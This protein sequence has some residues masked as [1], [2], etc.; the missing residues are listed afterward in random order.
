MFC[1]FRNHLNLPLCATWGKMHTWY[2]FT[3]VIYVKGVQRFALAPLFAVYVAVYRICHIYHIFR[4]ESCY[5]Y[6]RNASTH[7][8]DLIKQPRCSS[9]RWYR[10]HGNHD[11][12][13]SYSPNRLQVLISTL[14]FFIQIFDIR[15][16]LI[17]S[18][19]EIFPVFIRLAT[20]FRHSTEVGGNTAPDSALF[21]R[22][23]TSY[24]WCIFLYK[25]SA[26]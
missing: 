4:K 20:T 10:H 1:T 7:H 16:K 26:I 5:D 8:N 22:P 6:C 3:Y 23:Y 24:D 21:H 12:R 2:R 11:R 17:Y 13:G 19:R 18:C 25:N 14:M 9:T 15:Q